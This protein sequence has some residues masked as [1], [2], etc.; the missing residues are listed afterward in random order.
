M[1]KIREAMKQRLTNTTTKAEEGGYWHEE[2]VFY[3]REYRGDAFL[4][5]IRS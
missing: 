5:T 2:S 1:R 4:R 3:E